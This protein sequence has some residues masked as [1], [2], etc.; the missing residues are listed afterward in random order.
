MVTLKSFKK[1]IELCQKVNK[2][3]D[4]LSE[5][6]FDVIDSGMFDGFHRMMTLY[7]ESWLT[8]DGIEWVEWW[9]YELPNL[10]DEDKPHAQ[11]A[12]GTPIDIST[13]EKLYNFLQEYSI[14]NKKEED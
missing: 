10:K 4:K 8:E 6:G 1:A 9:L 5:V 7:L 12:D 2:D 14:D 3:C 13:I 11:Y